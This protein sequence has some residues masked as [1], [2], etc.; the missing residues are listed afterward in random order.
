[1]PENNAGIRIVTHFIAGEYIDKGGRRPP[2]II[3]RREMIKMFGLGT[4]VWAAILSVVAI[5]SDVIGNGGC[6]CGGNNGPTAG[7]CNRH[8]GCCPRNTGCGCRGNAD[9]DPFDR[10]CG[11][12]RG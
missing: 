6:G 3:K 10:G 12:G 5:H 7:G 9:D 1:M 11:C 8:N 4:A 2:G